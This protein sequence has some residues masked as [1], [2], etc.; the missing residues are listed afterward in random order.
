MK[1]TPDG[2]S[3][4]VT[5]RSS[6]GTSTIAV[7]DTGE[8]IRK[9]DIPKVFGRFCQLDTIDHHSEGTGLGMTISRSIIEHHSGTMWI[10][11]EHGRGTTV[12][13]T[14]PLAKERPV[15]SRDTSGDMQTAVVKSESAPSEPE[16]KKILIVDDDKTIRMAL[17]DCFR[18]VGFDT[19]EAADGN[20]ALH[21]VETQQPEVIILDVMMP[22]MSGIEVCRKLRDNPKTKRIKIIMLSARGQ[23]KEKEEGLKAGADRYVTKPFDYEE[24][25]SI[26]EKLL[27][28]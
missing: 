19:L 6:G 16:Q 8:G 18:K 4:R 25:M 3:I 13:F 22:G 27:G 28:N 1:F 12:F 11:S 21:V 14:L 7:K 5:L 10:E 26:V 17:T 24:L 23:E 9:E 20:E 2:C 15:H